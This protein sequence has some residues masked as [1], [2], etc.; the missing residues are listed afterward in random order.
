MDLGSVEE[1]MNINDS[2]DD[3]DLVTVRG[4]M[5]VLNNATASIH[6]S[7][8]LINYCFDDGSSRRL[9]YSVFLLDTLFRSQ[10]PR[11]AIGSLIIAA[12]LA[13]SINGT[14]AVRVNTTFHSSSDV[15]TKEYYIL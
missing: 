11:E 2:I 4:A 3:S 10:N 1:A 13:C 14:D 5:D 12:R 15:S 9:S 7:E 6:I 8:E